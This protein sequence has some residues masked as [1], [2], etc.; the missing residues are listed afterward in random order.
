MPS[1][2]YSRFQK[3]VAVFDSSWEFKVFLALKEQQV[4]FLYNF[5]VALLPNGRHHIIDFVF[6]DFDGVALEVRGVLNDRFLEQ[7]EGLKQLG[8]RVI[9]VCK[10]R[11]IIEVITDLANAVIPIEDLSPLRETIERLSEP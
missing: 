11:D 10:Q 3:K 2:K 4:N 1:L 8:Y 7:V 5:Q 6:P 9:V